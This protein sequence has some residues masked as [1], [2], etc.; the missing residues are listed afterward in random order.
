MEIDQLKWCVWIDKKGYKIY[1]FLERIHIRKKSHESEISRKKFTGKVTEQ[2]IHTLNT[3]GTGNAAQ[4]LELCHPILIFSMPAAQCTE[5]L[6]IQGGADK[7]LARPTSRYCRMELIVSLE[8]G[9]CSCAELQ[10]FS[11]YR[12]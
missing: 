11:C 3:S 7:S 10:V 1:K 2:L 9:V 8:I 4:V 5:F 6:F 12:G